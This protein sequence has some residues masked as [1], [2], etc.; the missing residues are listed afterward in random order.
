MNSKVEELCDKV[1]DLTVCELLLEFR[2][3]DLVTGTVEWKMDKE[4]LSFGFDGKIIHYNPKDFL[5]FATKGQVYVNRAYMHMILH[6]LFC[7]LFWK[8]QDDCF[9]LACDII[10]EYFIDHLNSR[11]LFIPLSKQRQE[12]YDE[13]EKHMELFTV[14]Q[15]QAYLHQYPIE[16]LQNL[17]QCFYVDSHQ[18]WKKLNSSEG[19][20]LSEAQKHWQAL[21]VQMRRQNKRRKP[22]IGKKSG[23]SL[24]KISLEKK[25]RK[26]YRQF[27]QQFMSTKEDSVLDLDSFDY[28]YYLYGLEHYEDMPL[29]EPLEYK[30]VT[31]LEQLVIAID[32][33][34]SCSGELVK[35][36]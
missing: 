34:G 24:E 22:M 32:T 29:I 15:V 10:V 4:I 11:N 21:G 30:E 9:D 16:D 8:K 3:L 14:D 25:K 5:M 19:L 33:S 20:S 23:H 6:G 36:F 12:V 35:L 27:L 7:H 28:I 26:D 13:I 1:W 18:L 2:F 31:R 17:K